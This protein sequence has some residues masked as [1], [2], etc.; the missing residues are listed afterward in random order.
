[1]EGSDLRGRVGGGPRR[2]GGVLQEK[3]SGRG[4][5]PLRGLG[6]PLQDVQGLR[7]PRPPGARAL[8]TTSMNAHPTV[9]TFL[10]WMEAAVVSAV[11]KVLTPYP[12]LI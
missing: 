5:R 9:N 7:A 10:I 12:P 11:E 8:M 6:G 1:M 2:D 4:P 3:G